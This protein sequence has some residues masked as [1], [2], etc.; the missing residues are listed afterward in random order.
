MLG[1]SLETNKKIILIIF[2]GDLVT[3]SPL[4][5]FYGGPVSDHIS[6]FMTISYSTPKT[7]KL[8][9]KGANSHLVILL[10]VS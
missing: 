9:L 1:F 5:C 10:S 7:R 6:N 8:D 3:S 4:Y 2:Q